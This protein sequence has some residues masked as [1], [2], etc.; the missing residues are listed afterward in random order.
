MHL[1]ES[2]DELQLL[3]SGDGPLVDFLEELDA[4]DPEAIPRGIRPI[5]YLRQ[6]AMARRSL[7]IHGNYLSYD[8]IGF[9]GAHNAQMSVVYCPRTHEYFGHAPYP[10]QQMLDAGV[11]VCLGTDSRASNPDLGLW[12]EMRTVALRHPDVSPES[13]LRMGTANGAR[14]LGFGNQTGVLVRGR[15]AD[16]TLVRLASDSVYD[17]WSSLF[18]DPAQAAMAFAAD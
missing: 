4:W 16:L 8:E 2:L 12:Q 6:L 3:K 9:A 14:A 15:R 7:V 17:P 11:N 10:L 18:G 1:A 13:I 5:N